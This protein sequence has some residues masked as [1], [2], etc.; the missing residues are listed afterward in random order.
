DGWNM[1]LPSL[2]ELFAKQTIGRTPPPADALGAGVAPPF[3][4]A[5]PAEARGD[6]VAEAER[7]GEVTAEMHIALAKGFGTSKVTGADWAAA[8]EEELERVLRPGDA[9]LAGKARA[10]I[11]RLR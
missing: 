6:F 3:E 2:R 7:I 10:I 4:G 5:D 11:N 1:A 9:A 8:M